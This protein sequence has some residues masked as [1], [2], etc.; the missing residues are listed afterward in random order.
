MKKKRLVKWQK[1]TLSIRTTWRTTKTFFDLH[2]LHD[3]PLLLDLPG[4]HFLPPFLLH[5]LPQTPTH[6][7]KLPSYQEEEEE[8]EKKWKSVRKRKGWKKNLVEAEQ[9]LKIP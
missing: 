4:W 9:K 5:I 8:E 2:D 1:K 7:I 6:F 3:F